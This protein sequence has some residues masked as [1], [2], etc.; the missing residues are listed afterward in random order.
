MNFYFWMTLFWSSCVVIAV[1]FSLWALI[2]YSLGYYDSFD[3]VGQPGGPFVTLMCAGWYHAIQ[4]EY[5]VWRLRRKLRKSQNDLNLSGCEHCD[6]RYS[7][8]KY[9]Q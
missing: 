3:I 5:T 1:S 4:Q 2:G 6:I 8:V 7:D 9:E